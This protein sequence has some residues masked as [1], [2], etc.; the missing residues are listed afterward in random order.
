MS[1]QNPIPFKTHRPSPKLEAVFCLLDDPDE[2][3]THPHLGRNEKRA[4]LA[5]WASDAFAVENQPAL[6]RLDNGKVIPVEQ[7]LKALKALDNMPDRAH[8]HSTRASSRPP[9]SRGRDILRAWRRQGQ[10]FRPDD[11][12][13]PPPCPAI[14]APRP[15]AP[16]G[17]GAMA[18]PELVNA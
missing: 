4:L 11:D 5:S 8:G 9:Y 6:R 13:D 15:R 12:D 17:I 18:R 10:S 16:G 1:K 14:I 7:T 2:V 3:V